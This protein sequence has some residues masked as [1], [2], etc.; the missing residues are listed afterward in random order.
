MAEEVKSAAEVYKE[1]YEK[2]QKENE[3]LKINAAKATAI[4]PTIEPTAASISPPKTNSSG[5][6][7][8]IRNEVEAFKQEVSKAVTSVIAQLNSY[9][10]QLTAF[11][12]EQEKIRMQ[13]RANYQSISGIANLIN[14]GGK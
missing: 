6:F 10:T 1:L 8:A 3:R 4:K 2:S 9:G 14:N 7:T 11:G 5:E 12:S 13:V